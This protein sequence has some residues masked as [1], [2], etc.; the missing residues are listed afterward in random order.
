MSAQ[1]RFIYG[2]VEEKYLGQF[3]RQGGRIFTDHDIQNVMAERKCDLGKALESW[4]DA[5]V[6]ETR[7]DT[8]V[9]VNS[10]VFNFLHD[11]YAKENVYYLDVQGTLHLVFSNPRLLNRLAALGPGEVLCDTN[12]EW[13]FNPKP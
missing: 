9:S 8:V 12:L 5:R 11:N 2:A 13:E 6:V 3:K 7:Y 10:L 4:V 1:T